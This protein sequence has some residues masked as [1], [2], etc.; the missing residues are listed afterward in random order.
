MWNAE[1]H[2]WSEVYSDRRKQ[3]IHT[4]SCEEA[5][6]N[7]TIYASGWGKKMSYVVGFSVDGAADVTRRYVRKADQ[8]LE[9][10][11]VTEEQLKSI[12][13]GL[14][15]DLRQGVSESEVNTLMQEDEAE[16]KELADYNDDEVQPPVARQS[17]SVEWTKARGEDGRK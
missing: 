6:N 2:V 16:E 5:W 15:R 17:G 1:D 7:P 3:W 8:Q 11:M 9:R 13:H 4:D 10:K 14:T 12:L